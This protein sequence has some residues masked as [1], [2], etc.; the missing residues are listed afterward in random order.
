MFSWKALLLLVAISVVASSTAFAQADATMP[1]NWMVS[2]AMSF[3]SIDTENAADRTNW[4]SVAPR[5]MYFPVENLS[6]GVEAN[7]LGIST[8]GNGNSFHNYLGMAQYTFKGKENFRPF[9]EAG[10]GL[11]R[12][13]IEDPLGNTI[14]NG[15]AAKAGIGAQMFINEHVAITPTISYMYQS[16]GD[17]GTAVR[18]SDQTIF[19]S[20][21]VSGF[22][23][24]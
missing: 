23:L 18:G 7:F 1:G 19:M 8:G 17:D 5:G 14:F 10:A 20:L 4:F 6:F 16:F 21:A 13:T 3:R 9:G 2:G 11:A 12:E 22:F 15:W 24:P